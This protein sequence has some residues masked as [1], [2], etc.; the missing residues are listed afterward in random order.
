MREKQ[1]VSSIII[2]GVIAS[3]GRFP[4]ACPELR[5]R[6]AIST[7][8]RTLSRLKHTPGSEE[9]ASAKN[10]LRDDTILSLFVATGAFSVA[11]LKTCQVSLI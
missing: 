3:H 7:L 4:R 11:F 9:I 1:I 10:L 5:R 2:M 6:M 8:A